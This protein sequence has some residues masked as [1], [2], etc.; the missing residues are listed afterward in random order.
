MFCNFQRW[1]EGTRSAL[2]AVT[3]MLSKWKER[4]IKKKPK[5]SFPVDMQNTD[6]EC[7]KKKTPKKQQLWEFIEG[8]S[9]Y[10]QMSFILL[11]TAMN[12]KIGP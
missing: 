12:Q 2:G 7:K 8:L 6:V 4:G 11:L 9:F 1:A 5:H 3:R 10:I